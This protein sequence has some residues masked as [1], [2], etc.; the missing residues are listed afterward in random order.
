MRTR[1]RIA[2]AGAWGVL[3]IALLV[4][5]GVTLNPP[6]RA[7]ATV[8]PAA[9]VASVGPSAGASITFNESGLPSGTPW[10]ASLWA[11]GVPGAPLTTLSTSASSQSVTAVASSG[12]IDFSIWTVPATAGSV[13]VASTD[14]AGPLVLSPTVVH[15]TFTERSEAGLSFGLHVVEEGLP[16][17][18]NWSV[19]VNGSGYGSHAVAQSAPAPGFSST[20]INAPTIY[21]S[22]GSA[23]QPVAY[24]LLPCTLIS[25]DA[26]WNNQTVGPF[27][28]TVRGPAYLLIDYALEYH[29][30][31]VSSLGG[32]A[33]PPSEWVTPGA[34]VTLT[35]TAS[36]G[37]TFL[38]WSGIGPGAVNSSS[39]VT[40][41]T[42]VSGPVV[43]LASFS[44]FRYTVVV[45]AFGLPTGQAFSV[46]YDG[47]PYS[48]FNGTIVLPAL[49]A[50][51]YSLTVPD[52]VANGTSWVRYVGTNLSTTLP[53]ANDSVLTVDRNGTVNIT[54]AP[55]Y[56]LT[57]TNTA[58]G[59]TTPG[60]GEYWE[61]PTA[62]VA[63]V[64]TPDTDWHFGGW[65]GT[66]SG[67]ADS[68]N[69]SVLLQLGGPVNETAL[70][71]PG[72]DVY[73]VQLTETGLPAGTP[74]SAAVGGLG[75]TATTPLLTISGVVVGTYTVV[76]P[77]VPVGYG[78]RFVAGPG[79]PIALAVANNT[80]Q[81][82]A[83]AAQ[84]LVTTLAG[85]GGTV[86]PAPGWVASGT[87]A[88]FSA[89]PDPGDEF[90]GWE[91]TVTSLAATLNLTVAGPINETA[92]FQAPPSQV[93]VPL[94]WYD[95]VAGFLAA[96]LIAF[97]GALWW[98]RRTPPATPS[99][100][101]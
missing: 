90:V 20:S 66:G 60:A 43:E 87:A 99:G 31:V 24:D 93:P 76:V 5:A 18:R 50:S 63:L 1:S 30:T 78:T 75:A 54:F 47:T 68:S 57:L 13:W 73:T 79:S 81:K 26:G 72:P 4:L 37:S 61:S 95:D 67:A 19:V 25:G 100:P 83:F 70:F 101:A 96:T 17:G 69:L 2:S 23:F 97:V 33:S 44:P 6:S 7:F 91:G 86:S 98:R 34:P 89:A 27:A 53:E 92:I 49:P 88:R 9:A 41:V 42:L 15:V 16:Q 55:Q 84:F 36:A 94:P 10:T 45:Q 52:V 32:S 8:P 38:N 40:A 82:I 51:V 56:A 35:A 22:N 80:T 3:L 65:R 74:W 46:L 12:A 77:S 28:V 48:S 59:T 62:P 39:P 71:L 21:L 29:L 14:P 58:G 11:Y 64:A 85:P